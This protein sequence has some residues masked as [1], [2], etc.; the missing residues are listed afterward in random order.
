MQPRAFAFLR[1]R[2]WQGDVLRTAFGPSFWG[3]AAAAAA[4]GGL[5]W[6]LK[7][8]DVVRD[9]LASDLRLLIDLLPRVLVALSIAALIWLM[10]PRERMAKMVGADSGLYGLA[11]A[12]VA[13]A[14][15]PG[16]PSSA[17]PLLA[18]LAVSGADRGALVAY[19]T[20]W[21]TLGLQRVLIWDVPFM[22]AEFALLRLA[23]TL[24]LPILAGLIARRL[25]LDLYIKDPA[26]P[27]GRTRV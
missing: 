10:L 12:S 16:G 13:G 3:F 8:P 25:P 15:T 9:A 26:S 17:Y 24:P 22:G 21:A 19:I 27:T 4:F 6:A 18:V 20:S 14:V 1:D 2:A 11:V 23:V 5:C 7:G